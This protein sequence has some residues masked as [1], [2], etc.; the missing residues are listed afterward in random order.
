MLPVTLPAKGPGDG[1][2]G[3]ESDA[4]IARYGVRPAA[5]LQPLVSP[6]RF[7]DL[8]GLSIEHV[9]NVVSQAWGG[10]RAAG[11]PRRGAR[12]VLIHLA[13]FPGETWQERWEASG[14][15]AVG[16]RV[17]DIAGPP[18]GRA[19][20]R[21]VMTAGLRALL[22]VRA[23]RPTLAALRSNR[24]LRLAETFRLV[25]GDELLDQFFEEV[26]SS[27]R[28]ATVRTAAVLDVTYALLSQGIG[29]RDLTPEVLLHYAIESGRLGVTPRAVG[30]AN[31]L[32]GGAAWDVLHRMGHFGPG[33]PHSL[34]VCL[35]NGQRT[36]A[37]LVDRHD[38][39]NADVREVLIE[40]LERRRPECDYSTWA[41]LS[42]RL[43]GQFWK[44]IE[45][46]DPHQKDLRLR[47]GT[48]EQWA[49]G[50][51][52]RADGR[53]RLRAGIDR[54]DRPQL[55]PGSAELGDRGTRAVGAVGGSMP[56]PARRW[57]Q[58]P[59]SSAKGDGADR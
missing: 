39:S 47:T 49:A 57:P 56:G 35:N 7:G 40:Y 18:I 9:T 46:I 34:K 8:S 20:R 41:A 48:Y 54:G 3:A 2:R 15:N 36:A 19:G 29:L 28:S 22:C 5:A 52:V 14:L 31:R 21:E 32:A 6:G 53:V 59:R 38:V 10:G 12:A 45:L 23:F 13:G 42:L 37:E 17:G 26:A 50:L 43:V 24:I 11:P 16:P 33:A 1:F 30:N 58:Q 51:R 4:R 25:E 44:K 55:L 27:G